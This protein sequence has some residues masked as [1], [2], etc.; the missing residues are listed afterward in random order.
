MSILFATLVLLVTIG[1][2]PIS[3]G[4]ALNAAHT[5]AA[6]LVAGAETDGLQGGYWG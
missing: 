5:P 6:T 1:L 4:V 2:R 3:K